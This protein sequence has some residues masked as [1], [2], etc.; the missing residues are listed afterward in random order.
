MN[1]VAQEK[2]TETNNYS[3]LKSLYLQGKERGRT[4]KKKDRF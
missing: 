4:R 1:Y 3:T 2:Y